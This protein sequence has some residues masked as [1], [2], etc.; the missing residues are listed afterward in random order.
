MCVMLYLGQGF[1]ELVV[2]AQALPHRTPSE[3]R[4]PTFPQGIPSLF[5]SF[6]IS[7]HSNFVVSQT[8]ARAS[9]DAGI[10]WHL[11]V[12][13]PLPYPWLFLQ[14][15][16]TGL[17]SLL[18]HPGL[19]LVPRDSAGKD[20]HS[21]IRSKGL[22]FMSQHW[23]SRC[24]LLSEDQFSLEYPQCTFHG[25]GFCPVSQAFP[26]AAQKLGFIFFTVVSS[27][28]WLVHSL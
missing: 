3:V 23:V 24:L 1:L 17:H 11:D 20:P 27:R 13:G 15:C 25:A 10:W 19:I 26:T 18:C 21:S 28:I 22:F 8:K 6:E 12:C 2:A 5:W 9:G 16:P 14:W 7:K 4:K